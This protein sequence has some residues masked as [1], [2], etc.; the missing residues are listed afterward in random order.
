MEAKPWKADYAFG[1]DVR[2]HVEARA[3]PKPVRLDSSI[4]ELF[5]QP[6]DGKQRG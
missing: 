5:N 6:A 2:S 4:L 1:A 3:T